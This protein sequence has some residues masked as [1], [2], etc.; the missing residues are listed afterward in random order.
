VDTEKVSS[1]SLLP[2]AT[3]MPLAMHLLLKFS[4][5]QSTRA[6]QDDATNGPTNAEGNA[7]GKLCFRGQTP[8]RLLVF[9]FN[10]FGHNIGG[11]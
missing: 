5:L 6:A 1:A 7:L 8:G 3:L 4:L 10:E 2:P 9:R 11:V